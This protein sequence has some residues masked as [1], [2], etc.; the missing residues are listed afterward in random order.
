MSLSLLVWSA[1][2]LKG[3][4]HDKESR[5]TVRRAGAHERPRRRGRLHFRKTRKSDPIDANSLNER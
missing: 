2:E 4:P 3:Q 5:D 1:D